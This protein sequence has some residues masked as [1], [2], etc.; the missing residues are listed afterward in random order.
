MNGWD[1][2]PNAHGCAG[3][4]KGHNC[5]DAGG[6]ATQ[7]V[8][9][10]DVRSDLSSQYSLD[11]VLSLSTEITINNQFT[12]LRDSHRAIAPPNAHLIMRNL[13]LCPKV[14]N[15]VLANGLLV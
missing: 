8:K 10:K 9:A 3:V 7:E 11:S 15:R 1:T 4:A 6:R 12:A 2:Y 5:K 14:S 13:I